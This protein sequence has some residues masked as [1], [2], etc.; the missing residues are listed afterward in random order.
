MDFDTNVENYTNEELLQLL[1][2]TDT[3]NE[4]V[5][6]ATQQEIDKHEENKEIVNF[7]LDIRNRLVEP[8]E[9]TKVFEAT[10]KKGTINPDLKN[11]VSRMINIDSSYR[12]ISITNLVDSDNYVFTLNE[13]INNVTS[14]T[15]YSIE[16]PQSWYTFAATKGNTQLKMVLVQ[17]TED[18]TSFKNLEYPI[19]TIKDGNYTTKALLLHLKS[20][21]AASN[22][23]VNQANNSFD[24]VQDPYTGKFNF[25]INS[26]FNFRYMLLP[27]IDPADVV[28]SS[29]VIIPP[30]NVIVPP[31]IFPP[32]TDPY[33]VPYFKFLSNPP[34]EPIVLKA[35]K[36]KLSFIF[37]NQTDLNNKINYN[38]GWILGF[39]L[40]AVIMEDAINGFDG[41]TTNKESKIIFIPYS[42][43]DTAGTKY[44]ILK[45]DDYKSNRLNNGLVCINVKMEKSIRPPSY[46][47]T[48]LSKFT[49]S[50]N[51]VNVLPSAPN[52]N[53]T[54]KQIY[55]IN[56]IAD[57]KLYQNTLI[58]NQRVKFP[59]DSDIFAKIPIKRASEW[60]AVDSAGNYTA[61][62]NGPG[63]LII[64]FSGPVQLN[65]REYFG[66]VN[67]TSFAVSLYD[68]KG[69]L[70]GLNGLDWSFTIIA[71]SIYQY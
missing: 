9:T 14:L 5:I 65:S 54:A 30:V 55:T 25:V 20:L 8:E 48:T 50:K 49:T 15:L 10:V 60:G 28:D 35:Y 36:Y 43:I 18:N 17:Y 19:I 32:I 40:P 37:H 7:Y 26:N 21:I 2:I 53:L 41:G 64:E 34:F 47:N 29:G 61:I 62:D 66:P 31:P 13:P 33:Y 38:L 58:N 12:D 1:D 67:M 23:F 39:R 46:Y 4:S 22:I 68:D 24:I 59:E 71:K 44:I 69:M 52:N 56:S 11:T 70:L 6:I 16:L 3:S 42:L 57:D 45:L 27:D 63:K 51:T